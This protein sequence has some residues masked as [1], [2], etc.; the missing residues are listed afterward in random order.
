[1]PSFN[2]YREIY[3]EMKKKFGYAIAAIAALSVAASA[4]ALVACGD[5][6]K[7]ETPQGV[8]S[9]KFDANGGMF[10]GNVSTLSLPTANGRLASMPAAPTNG[11]RAF[12]GYTFNRDGSGDRVSLD[13]VF[14]ASTTVYAQWGEQDQPPVEYTVTFDANGGEFADGAVTSLKTSGGKLT[15]FVQNPFR[16]DYKFGGWYL[17]ADPAETD[18]PVAL[19]YTYTED[20]TVYAGWE[21]DSAP[22]EPVGVYEITFDANGGKIL[23]ESTV[24]LNTANGMLSSLPADAVRE[25]FKFVGWFNAAEGGNRV[26][27]A[28]VYDGASTVYAQWEAEEENPGDDDLELHAFYLVGDMTDDW[29]ILPQY[30]LQSV[31]PSEDMTEQYSV[32]FT[33]AAA[34]M[35]IKLWYN[36]GTADGDWNTRI[37]EIYIDGVKLTAEENGNYVI[38]EAGEYTLY[39]KVYGEWI[40]IDIVKKIVLPDPS[41]LSV[42]VGGTAL[43]VNADNADENFIEYMNVVGV[44]LRANEKLKVTVNGEESQVYVSQDSKGIDT[45]VIDR[46]VDEITAIARGTFTFY[47]KF[48]GRNWTVHTEF[49]EYV[50]EEAEPLDITFDANGGT[51]EVTTLKTDKFGKLAELPEPTPPAGMRFIGWFTAKTDGRQ[52]TTATVFDAAATVYALYEKAPVSPVFEINEGNKDTTFTEYMATGVAVKAGEEIE[53]VIDGEVKSVTVKG[54]RGLSQAEDGTVTAARGGT[55]AFYVKNYKNNPSYWEVYATDGVNENVYYLVG[56]M[57][58]SNWL[59][60]DKYIL[61]E[62]GKDNTGRTQYSITLEL[63][64]GDEVRIWKSENLWYNNLKGTADG[65]ITLKGDNMLVGANGLYKFWFNSNEEIYVEALVG[66]QTVTFDAGAGTIAT[67]TAKTGL[68]GRLAE[69]PVPTAPDGKRFTGW[70]TA[71]TGGEKITTDTV[72]EAA[73]TVY[74]R[75]EDETVPPTLYTVTFDAHDG[76]LDGATTATTDENGKLAE[77]PTPTAPSGYRFVGWFTALIG[78]DEVTT[79]YVF[80]ADKTV[81]AV[82]EKIDVAPVIGM[83][84]GGAAAVTVE[85]NKDAETD[86]TNL[87]YEYMAL[88]VELAANDV[89]SFEKDGEALGAFNLDPNSHGVSLVGGSLKVKEAGAFDIYVRYYDTDPDTGNPPCWVVEMT[90]GKEDVLTD[91]AYYLVGDMNGWNTAAEFELKNGSVTVYLDE[92]TGF[93]IRQHNGTDAFWYGYTSVQRG[94]SYV[95]DNGGNIK[96]KASG[97]YTVSLANNVI[98]ITS[99][100]VAEPEYTKLPNTYYLVGTITGWDIDPDYKYILTVNPANEKEYMVTITLTG[101]EE[102]KVCKGDGTWSGG[103]NAAITEAG[104]YTVYFDS[105]QNKIVYVAKVK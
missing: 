64:T 97:T 41:T 15:A 63:K 55:F 4:G 38:P 89:I 16:T 82:Y 60:A 90:D 73:A 3:G 11:E 98:S 44:E 78:G 75:Y 5:S 22:V 2:L 57:S 12:N 10:A 92:G 21:D 86:G 51:L 80:V 40:R 66:E 24:K 26:T 96:I 79:D 56:N 68:D 35:H 65:K 95:S 101:A 18:E 91:G 59:W 99:E 30:M 43:A 49:V 85:R 52:I 45:S 46:K 48:D 87:V 58:D 62:D 17:S 39:Y 76:T 7:P 104:T 61:A 19:D 20:V 69:L 93:K 53:F 27:A 13:T 70:F 105:Q 84:V 31:A 14:T 29:K 74:A 81:H 103:D 77:L 72:F 1:M 100:D 102:L 34:D 28:T 9:I 37:D 23:G 33:T 54:A 42:A 88:K 6:D 32:K 50:P 47:V 36:S 71:E 67:P 83:K 8:Y 94:R 25:G